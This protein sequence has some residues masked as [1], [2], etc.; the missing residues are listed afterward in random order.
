MAE[1]A[2]TRPLRGAETP[3]REALEE[4]PCSLLRYVEGPDGRLELRDTPLTPEDFLDPQIGDILVQGRPHDKV[5]RD[6]TDLLE[7]GLA[8]RS[9]VLVVHELKHLLGPGLPGPGPDISVI[10]GLRDPDP[11]MTSYDVAATGI[12]P[13]LIIEVISPS[14]RRIREVD[15]RVKP[16]LYARIGVEEYVMVD[17]PRRAN[18]RRF[19]LRGQ[20]L[21]ERGRYQPMEPDA[22]GRLVSRVTGLLFGVSAQGDRIEVF[23]AATGER[24]LSSKEEE[25]RRKAAE[26]QAAREAEGRKAAEAELAR[27][28]EEL[29]R[30]RG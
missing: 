10:V 3:L 20:R 19:Q 5:A 30:L 6:L 17:L 2:R 1:P 21:E 16:T 14:D 23:V 24:L 8:S 28:R 7:R 12:P 15:E 27:L 22:Q 25:E 13:S 9:D 26:E 29:R 18:N 11:D 4:S